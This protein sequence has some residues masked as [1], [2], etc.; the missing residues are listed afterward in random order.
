MEN[1][2]ADSPEIQFIGEEELEQ[3]QQDV[4]EFLPQIEEWLATEQHAALEE[5]I[6]EL[7]P[8]DLAAILYALDFDQ[9]SLFFNRIPFS[10][11]GET[12]YEMPEKLAYRFLHSGMTPADI[13]QSCKGLAS[14]MI[15]DLLGLLHVREIGDI[16]VHLSFK[17]RSLILELLSYPED[18]A[19]ALMDKGFIG[20]QEHQTI[21][22]AISSL[23]KYG[24]EIDDVHTIYV[25]DKMGRYRGNVSLSRMILSRPQTKIKRIMET[26][27]RPIPVDMDQEQVAD[28]FTRYNLI[29]APVVDEQGI[30]LGRITVDDIL[31]VVREEASEDILRMGGMSGEETL[32]T[33]VWKSSLQR[34]AWLA[35][36]LLTAFLSA[37]V[38]KSFEDTIA[39]IVILAAL[40]PIVAG[41]GGNA[42]SQ[43]LALVVRNLA[44]GELNQA[45]AWKTFG[46]EFIIGILNG[47]GIGVLTGLVVFAFTDSSTLA[48][49]VCLALIA[50]MLI[51]AIAGS[52]LPILLQ[53]IGVDPAIASGI[54]VTT[55]TDTLGF[56]VF[57]G[58]AWLAIPWLAA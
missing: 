20:V 51:A 58:L 54:L 1:T 36:N 48:A 17:E 23:R 39:R 7:H 14:D 19:G 26:E 27:I 29:T 13:A 34:I 9:A 25:I 42:G 32:D 3:I 21:H 40:M 56:F 44:L 31:E 33:P 6:S 12:L 5:L 55:C 43:T 35:V 45:N 10:E 47:L 28:F 57:L 16:L 46:R 2:L 52:T 38:V 22:K 18:T 50:N 30:M 49:I 8:N 53:K 24:R 15:A 4:L 41:M 11:R 37:A